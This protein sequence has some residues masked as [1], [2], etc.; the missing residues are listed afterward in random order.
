MKNLWKTRN[1]MN[2]RNQKSL[3]DKHSTSRTDHDNIT[4]IWTYH[5]VLQSLH[6]LSTVE[7]SLDKSHSWQGN[8]HWPDNLSCVYARLSDC[9]ITQSVNAVHAALF[10]S[11]TPSM[12]VC[13]Q[14]FSVA[15]PKLWSCYPFMIFPAGSAMPLKV[16]FSELFWIAFLAICRF[17]GALWICKMECYFRMH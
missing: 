14:P 6:W 17:S 7:S 9:Q 10:F 1:H 11:C 16:E 8:T 12:M 3:E 15:G 13:F 5:H 2:T 4:E